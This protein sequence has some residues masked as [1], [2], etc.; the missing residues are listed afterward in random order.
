MALVTV[1]DIETYMDIS[2]TNKQEDAAEI[3]IAGLE[4]ELEA[5]LDRP[6]VQGTFTETHRVP[7]D[8]MGHT[9]NSFYYD[10]GLSDALAP[11]TPRVI[12]TPAHVVY[13]QNS[14]VLSVTTVTITSPYP[15]ATP[16][17]L[18]AE[19]DY[20]TRP[21]GIEITNAYANDRVTVTYVAGLDGGNIPLF[22][23]LILRAAAREMQN[24]YDDTV[25]LKD[26]TTRNIA[27]LETGFTERELLSVK[28]YKRVRIS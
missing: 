18:V 20:V 19:S 14:P 7:N 10:Y 25:G 6:L 26:L 23:S 3:I 4:A 22:K 16:R 9:E 13:L 15:D 5:F 28:K 17:T 27:P 8:V 24:M 11:Y 12:Y 2:L 1:S 21:F